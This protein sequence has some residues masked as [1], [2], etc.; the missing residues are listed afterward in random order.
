MPMAA[1]AVNDKVRKAPWDEPRLLVRDVV[2]RLVNHLVWMGHINESVWEHYPRL[3]R[4]K[5][6]GLHERWV[7]TLLTPDLEL[8]G[9]DAEVLELCQQIDAWRDATGVR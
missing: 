5:P 9:E 2:M 6:V 4:R 7:E 1:R 3:R 8:K